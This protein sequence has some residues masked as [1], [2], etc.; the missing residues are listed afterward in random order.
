[1]FL[2]LLYRIMSQ[3]K[4]I[5]LM[6]VFLYK[7][8]FHDFKVCFCNWKP[9]KKKEKTANVVFYFESTAPVRW[10]LTRV[11]MWLA[12][13][14][15]ASGVNKTSGRFSAVVNVIAVLAGLC[16]ICEP[17]RGE[18]RT[19]V[20][21]KAS[22]QLSVVEGYREDFVAWANFTDDIKTSGW[23]HCR[24]LWLCR[25]KHSPPAPQPS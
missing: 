16:L 14:N 24:L 1:M 11:I 10:P 19:A 4:M 2:H 18:I 12:H 7:V 9:Q 20:I 15:M 3:N 17:V 13:S 22:G 8:I 25:S 5:G 21:D 23:V 6:S